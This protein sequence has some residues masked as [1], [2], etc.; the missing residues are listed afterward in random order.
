MTTDVSEEYTAPIFRVGSQAV[1]QG[2]QAAVMTVSLNTGDWKKTW[3]GAG[4]GAV[5]NPAFI[6]YEVAEGSQFWRFPCTASSPFWGK[7]SGRQRRALGREEG[8]AM[9]SEEGKT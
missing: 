7:V 9:G 6:G 5:R 2:K 1:N 8:K 3:Q 4:A